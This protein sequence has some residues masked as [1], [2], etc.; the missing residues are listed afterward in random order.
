MNCTNAESQMSEYLD[1]ALSRP[2]IAIL[3]IH[4]SSCDGCRALRESMEAV[5][6]WGRQFPEFVPPEWLLTRILANTPRTQRETCWNTVAGIGRWVLDTRTAM[7]V[8]TAS[9]MLGWMTNVMGVS[10]DP[11]QLRNPQAIYYT[12]DDLVG[13]A[14]DRVVRL[15]YQAPLLGEIQSR[16]EQLRDSS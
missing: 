8:F 6:E 16:I 9:V 11:A 4:M 13:E 5:L 10:L 7:A 12:V 3:E 15:Y 1:D 14:Y 2:E